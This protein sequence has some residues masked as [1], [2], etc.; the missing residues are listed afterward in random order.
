M[1]SLVK[2]M[3]EKIISKDRKCMS[4]DFMHLLEQNLMKLSIEY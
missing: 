4:T 1:L 3:H 2:K